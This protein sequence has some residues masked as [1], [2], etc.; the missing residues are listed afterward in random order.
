MQIS[1]EGRVKTEGK[2][3]HK[4]NRHSKIQPTVDTLPKNIFF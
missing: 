4:Q 1:I 3:T 2:D